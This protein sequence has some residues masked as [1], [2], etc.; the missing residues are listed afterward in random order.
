MTQGGGGIGILALSESL[1]AGNGAINVNPNPNVNPPGPIDTT[2]GLNA[3]GILADSGTIL[4]NH[5]GDPTATSSGPVQVTAKNISSTGQYSVGISATGITGSVTAK[6]LSGG[7]VM[8]GSQADP[9]Q[10]NPT[11]VGPTYGLSAA[12]VVLGSAGGIATLPIAT[13]INDGSI[14]ALSDLAVASPSSSF[15]GDPSFPPFPTSNNTT[16]INNSDGTITGFTQLVGG[17]NSIVN[18]GTFNLRHFAD[19]TG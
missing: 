8:G 10:S 9:W 4:N 2:N 1:G 18:N 5:N 19:T 15:H 11:K 16:I 6:V 7:L 12:G 13:L 17:N 3:I 14:G